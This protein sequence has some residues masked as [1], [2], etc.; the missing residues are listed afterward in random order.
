[1]YDTLYAFYNIIVIWRIN[2]C[3]F[4]I[5]S[6]AFV[7]INIYLYIISSFLSRFVT[8]IIVYSSSLYSFFFLLQPYFER[9]NRDVTRY[10]GDSNVKRSRRRFAKRLQHDQVVQQMNDYYMS[11]HY[12][13]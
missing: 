12:E 5:A 1:M 13:Y 7:F 8:N 6:F 9:R 3:S 2:L 10:V 11:K 4:F